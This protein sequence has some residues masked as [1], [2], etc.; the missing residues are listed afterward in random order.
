MKF[1]V[2][3]IC[4][5]CGLLLFASGTLTACNDNDKGRQGVEEYPEVGYANTAGS[6][7][8]LS[9]DGEPLNE[10]TYAY[11]RM[12]RRMIEDSDVGWRAFQT[13][14]TLSSAQPIK[15]TGLYIL[16]K[17]ARGRATIEGV[18]DYHGYWQK[19]FYYISVS[20]DNNTMT[21]TANDDPS[22]VAVYTRVDDNTLDEIIN[23]IND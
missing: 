2:K 14:S 7:K 4:K 17:D 6:W 3:N 13:Y 11:L 5:I 1:V 19:T 10:N 22:N 8:Q 18:Y 9:L 23:T 16:K 21:W 20:D 12:E 15:K